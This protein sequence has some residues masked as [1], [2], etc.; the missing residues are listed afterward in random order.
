MSFSARYTK[1]LFFIFILGFFSVGTALSIEEED[2]EEEF[3]IGGDEHEPNNDYNSKK[4][5]TARCDIRSECRSLEIVVQ[6]TIHD[7]NDEDWYRLD[8]DVNSMSNGQFSAF[9]INIPQGVDYDITAFNLDHQPIASSEN[10]GNSDESLQ[11]N[12]PWDGES[13]YLS[14]GTTIRVRSKSGFNCSHPYTLITTL[15]G[16]L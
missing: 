15:T 16:S 14:W 12:I 5:L 8:F 1:V 6:G 13:Y 7:Q 3:C 4:W 9:L 10:P 2:R 11:I